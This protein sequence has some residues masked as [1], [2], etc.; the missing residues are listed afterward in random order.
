VFR[1]LKTLHEAR[2]G[3][4]LL[5]T[6][7]T[8]AIIAAP[9]AAQSCKAPPGMSAIDQYCEAIPSP[10]GDRGN[11][12]AD[13]G[14]VPIPAAAK[15]ALER[16]GPDGQAIVGLSQASAKQAGGSGRTT[17]SP[18]GQVPASVHPDAQ[19]RNPATAI[20]SGFGDTG[21]AVGPLFGT[22]L[23]FLA[24]VFFATAWLRYRRRAQS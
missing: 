13:R 4:S 15:R 6:A 22:V 21:D 19:S 7:L 11:G 3:L 23:L 18:R 14:G 5:V 20:V 8:A 24:L 17:T 12:D 1:H 16:H 2:W 10:G 9:A